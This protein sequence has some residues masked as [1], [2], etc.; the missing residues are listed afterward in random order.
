MDWIALIVFVAVWIVGLVATLVPILPSSLIVW[1]GI[2]LYA[3][4]TGFVEIGWVWLAVLG[5]VAFGASWIDNVAGAWGVRRYGGSGG[6][7][8]GAFLGGLVGFGLG[9]IGF[10]I[11][12]F[13]GAF[14]VEWFLGKRRLA[15][16]IPPENRLEASKSNLRQ[17]LRSSQGT[18]L[19]LGVGIGLKGIVHLLMGLAVLLRIAI[20]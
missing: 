14:L 19:G 17:A 6:A 15:T 2:C 20:G 1:L 12:P 10:L 3:W 5:I 4:M 7:I 8:W 9:P 11:G 18:W 13:L 16:V